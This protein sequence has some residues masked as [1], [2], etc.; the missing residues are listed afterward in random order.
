MPCKNIIARAIV[1]L[2]ALVPAASSPMFSKIVDQDSQKLVAKLTGAPVTSHRTS[3]TV[4]SEAI[5]VTR[6]K[7][8]KYRSLFSCA[9]VTLINSSAALMIDAV[10]NSVR[11][12][13]GRCISFSEYLRYDESSMLARAKDSVDKFRKL[14]PGGVERHL[15]PPAAGCGNKPRFDKAVNKLLQTERR[16]S[17]LVHVAGSYLMISWRSVV[18]LQSRSST[19]GGVICRCSCQVGLGGQPSVAGSVQSG[20]EMRYDRWSWRHCE[21]RA[22]V[23]QQ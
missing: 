1:R 9:A 19:K 20:P 2:A 5:G 4:E 21:G 17:L 13:G 10:V 8:T 7:L 23:F 16:Y 14:G 18:P 3:I 12:R 11:S 6:W 15:P 22:C